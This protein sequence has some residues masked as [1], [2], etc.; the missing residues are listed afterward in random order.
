MRQADIPSLRSLAARAGVSRWQVQQLRQGRLDRMRLAVL[1][2]LAVAL[3]CSLPALLA[4]FSKA[5]AETGLPP[6]PDIAQL[7]Q[8][9]ERLR[10]ALDR[11]EVE[12]RQQLQ[13]QA[14]NQLEPWL[15]YWPTA[16]KAATERPDFD[17]K[18]L[19]PLVKPV[20]QL[21]ASWGVTAMGQV[22]EQL[23]YD[24]TWQQLVKGSAQ[25]GNL[26]RVSHLG[27]RHGER[28]L[29]RAKVAALGI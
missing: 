24:P 18:H 16:A 13:Q 27:Y 17:P 9:Y 7:Q 2:Q 22:G 11:Q 3:R 25:P 5:E 10:A 14:L 6:A 29:L 15:T 1:Q 28:L 4:A 26:V 8:E 21:V 19:L 23:P 20:E 12:L